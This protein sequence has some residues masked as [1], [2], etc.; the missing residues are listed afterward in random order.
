MKAN[1]LRSI[2]VSALLLPLG[3]LPTHGAIAK[4]ETRSSQMGVVAYIQGGNLWVKEL[5]DGQAERLTTDEGITSPRWSPSGHW[6]AYK[7]PG[8]CRTFWWTN[9]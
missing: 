1:V 8:L 4:Q 7:G 6:L 9:G 3:I 2:F 5:A